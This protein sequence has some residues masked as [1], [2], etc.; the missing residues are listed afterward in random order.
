[1]NSLI[2]YGAAIAMVLAALF[3]AYHHGCSVTQAAADLASEKAARQAITDQKALGEFYRQ[4][5]KTTAEAMAVIDKQHQEDLRNAQLISERSIAG[6]RDGTIR[7]RSKFAACTADHSGVPE[8][9][10]G[11]SVR[12][13]DAGSG[14][15]REDV[16]VLLREAARADE[17]VSQL[18]ACQAIIKLDRGVN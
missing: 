18:S 13:A 9:A 2:K 8:D 17:V 6:L 14:L 3:G 4:R 7:L 1:M 15:Q 11:A 5:E 16:D 10:T 12:D